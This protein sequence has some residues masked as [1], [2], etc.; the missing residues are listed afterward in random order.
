MLQQ[1][2]CGGRADITSAC[3]EYTSS[4]IPIAQKISSRATTRAA[5]DV[6][7]H[8]LSFIKSGVLQVVRNLHICILLICGERQKRERHV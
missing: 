3:T 8:E 1:I 2:K 4:I 5:I 7:L 6:I